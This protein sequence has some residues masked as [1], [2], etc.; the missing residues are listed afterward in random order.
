[1]RKHM[2]D[3]LASLDIDPLWEEPAPPPPQSPMRVQ[4]LEAALTFVRSAACLPVVK[5]IALIGS[6]TTPEP[7]PK[8]IDVLVTVTDD[9]S[10]APLAKVARQLNGRAMQSGRSRGG[11]VFLA[12]VGG[13]YLGW[14]CPW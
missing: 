7:S 8:D 13:N 14:T 2:T 3:W 1:M 10:L 4:L 12:D 6:L 5:R 11:D 9:M